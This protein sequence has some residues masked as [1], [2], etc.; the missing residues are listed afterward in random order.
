METVPPQSASKP[1][2]HD[3]GFWDILSIHPAEPPRWDDDFRQAA[4]EVD[5]DS[6]ILV[7]HV[8]WVE[9]NTTPHFVRRY[10]DEKQESDY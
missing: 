8:T 5:R 1:T 6:V 9:V 3:E 10:R 7:H 4:L 2:A